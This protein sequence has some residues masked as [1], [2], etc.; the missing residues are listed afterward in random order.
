MHKA[1]KFT[2]IN[3]TIRNIFYCVKFSTPVT[4]FEIAALVTNAAV[5]VGWDQFAFCSARVHKCETRIATR[6]YTAAVS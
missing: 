3:F 2:R 5:D 4:I 1:K 6:A